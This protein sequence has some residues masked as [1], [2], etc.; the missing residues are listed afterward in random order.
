[1][2][3]STDMMPGFWSSAAAGQTG[4]GAVIDKIAPYTGPRQRYVC[5]SW[6]WMSRSD[7]RYARRADVA[8]STSE[9]ARSETWLGTLGPAGARRVVQRAAG[10]PAFRSRRACYW[11]SGVVSSRGRSASV[12]ARS[13]PDFGYVNTLEPKEGLGCARRVSRVA[14]LFSVLCAVSDTPARD[15]PR[16]TGPRTAVRYSAKTVP[17]AAGW[18]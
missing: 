14:C 18:G 5:L 6:A 12:R 13:R 1:M 10:R 15:A 2:G 7:L 4:L 8:V 9:E 3:V 16:S 11:I 17:K